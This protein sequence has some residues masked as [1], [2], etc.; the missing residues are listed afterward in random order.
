M[1]HIGI[2]GLGNMGIGMAKNLIQA[3]FAVVGFDLRAERGQ[4]LVE[5]GG[6]S[7]DSLADLAQGG[8]GCFCDGF[9]WPAGA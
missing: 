4:M 1:K 2:V 7:V 8:R 5:L 9:E 3:G 6:E